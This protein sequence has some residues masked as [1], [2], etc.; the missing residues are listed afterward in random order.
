MDAWHQRPT[1]SAPGPGLY[2][3]FLYVG[4]GLHTDIAYTLEANFPN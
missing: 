1:Q 2:Y 4:S 3:I